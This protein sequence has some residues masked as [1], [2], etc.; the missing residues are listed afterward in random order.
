[1]MPKISEFFGISIHI[2]YREHLPPHFHAVYGD[3][4]ALVTIDNLSIFSGRLS[5][6]AMG[7]VV[8]WASLHQQELRHVWGQAMEHQPLDRIEPLR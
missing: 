2:F 1:M 5:P 7:L 4:E 3:E 6:R 8:E